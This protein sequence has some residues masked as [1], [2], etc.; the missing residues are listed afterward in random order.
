MTD[1]VV[2]SVVAPVLMSLLLASCG[3]SGSAQAATSGQLVI[4]AS[5]WKFD[6]SATQLTA[7]KPVTVSL[8]NQGKLEHDLKI[9]GLT[10]DSKEVLLNALSGRTAS[11][12]LTPEKAGTY[13]F[14]CTLPGHQEAGM[15]GQ[16]V[17]VGQ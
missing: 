15:K 6:A 12:K 5:E 10:A 16:L 11:V 8:Q 3:S 1:H 14:F 7:G 17:V 2:R 4:K 9:E 13:R